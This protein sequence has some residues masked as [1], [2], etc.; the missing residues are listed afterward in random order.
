MKCYS[1]PTTALPTLL[2]LASLIIT[3][4]CT[5]QTAMG[6]EPLDPPN[7][8]ASYVEKRYR[9]LKK[10]IIIDCGWFSGWNAALEARRIY[11]R[12]KLPFP[13][14]QPS[15]PQ[16]IYI[17][18]ALAHPGMEWGRL[19]GFCTNL[20]KGRKLSKPGQKLPIVGPLENLLCCCVRRNMVTR[21]K[22][23]PRSLHSFCPEWPGKPVQ[24][25]AYSECYLMCLL[26]HWHYLWNQPGQI[27]TAISGLERR[28]GIAL[29]AKENATW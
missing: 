14:R 22:V 27:S 10:K 29:A 5:P 28:R 18:R 20:D 4:T 21:E 23:F 15:G 8:G 12:N 24:C 16:N 25:H 3:H 17:H 7:H 1:L 6:E 13:F 26:W 9:K 19:P 2:P 11:W